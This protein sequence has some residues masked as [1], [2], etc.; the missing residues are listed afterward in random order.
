M[1]HQRS[2][3]QHDLLVELAREKKIAGAVVIGDFKLANRLAETGILVVHR[4][5]GPI[6]DD[7]GQIRGQPSD[8]ELGWITW[9]K[10]MIQLQ[11]RELHRDVIIQPH[12]ERY[13]TP[14][15]GYYVLGLLKAGTAYKR[16]LGVLGDSNA[17]P[18]DLYTVE[19][20]IAKSPTWKQRIEAMR[21]GKANGHFLVLHQY[22]LQIGMTPTNHPGSAIWP[23]GH[24]DENEWF[25]FGGRHEAV[26]RDIIPPE[27]RM[28][29]I[30]A[31]CGASAANFEGIGGTPGVLNDFAG[32]QTR[33]GSDPNIVFFAYWMVG[34]APPFEY[35]DISPALPTLA[36]YLR[37]R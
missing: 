21:Y 10:D 1:V 9:Q 32:Y 22:G 5:P 14:D 34:S 18:A 25:W 3:Q 24:T 31:E 20:K 17:Q 6:D 26:Y 30:V 35:S 8:E 27:A 7:F 23:D 2:Y 11:H 16:R 37:A 19:N 33:Y 15:D 12:N 4:I 36:A 28:P 13:A 29:I